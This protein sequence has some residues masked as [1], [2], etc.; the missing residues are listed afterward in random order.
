MRRIV[1]PLVTTASVTAD[2]GAITA[3]NVGV[4]VE[5]VVHVYVDV[6]AAPTTTPS[7]TAATPGCA[8]CQTDTERNR[9]RRNDSAS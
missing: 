1:L 8:N 2:V 9:T 5:V 3:L 6:V 7:P 4:A